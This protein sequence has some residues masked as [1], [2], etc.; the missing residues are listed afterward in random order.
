MCELYFKCRHTYSNG[1]K[2]KDYAYY[3][4]KENGVITTLSKS[5]KRVTTAKSLILPVG[6][7]TSSKDEFEIVLKEIIR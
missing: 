5:K 1:D 6:F 4:I 3:R 2:V 7:E